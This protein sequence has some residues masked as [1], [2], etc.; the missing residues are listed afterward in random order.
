MSLTTS[1]RT[2]KTFSLP[3]LQPD[4]SNWII[5]QDSVELECASHNLKGHLDGSRARP[6]PPEA[7]ITLAEQEA[8][9]RETARWTSGEATIRKGLAEALPLMLYLTVRK[10]PTVKE[11]WTKVVRHHQDKAQ[12][13]VVE[14]RTR[15][16]NERCPVKGNVHE[17]LSKLRQMRENLAQMGEAISDENFQTIILAS[18]PLAYDNF[19]TSIMNQFSPIPITVHVPQ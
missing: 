7:T 17:H 15:L 2:T 11:V 6:T 12:L 3:K 14:L 5:F 4:G 1:A 10:E 13:I 9:E 8:L 16:Q 18:L 19:L